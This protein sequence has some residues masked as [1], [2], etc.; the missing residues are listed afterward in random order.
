M[1][2]TINVLENHRDADRRWPGYILGGRIRTST[3]VLIIAFFLTWWTYNTYRPHPPPPVVPQVVPPGYVPDPNYT[4]VPRTR[5]QSP[6]SETPTTTVTTTTPPTTP[7]T[8]TTPPPLIQLPVLPPPFGPGAPTPTP[9]PG[10]V[11]GSPVPAP[12]PAPGL[13]ELPGVPSRPE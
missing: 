2:L 9:S 8:T 12:A 1:K 13:P 6:T 3:L 11:P 10:L 7:P 4:W 5:V